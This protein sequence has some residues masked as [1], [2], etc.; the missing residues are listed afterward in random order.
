MALGAIP[1]TRVPL[2]ASNSRAT[3]LVSNNFTA[4]LRL[5]S[6]L[7]VVVVLIQWI[8]DILIIE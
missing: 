5:H 1:L 2:P 8:D 4:P 3:V 7:P 6:E